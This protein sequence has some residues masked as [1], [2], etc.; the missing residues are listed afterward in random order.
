M[1]Y[2]DDPGTFA[3]DDQYL[4]GESLLVAPAFAGQQARSVYLPP[5][6]WFDFWTA[7][8]HSGKGRVEVDVP[9]DRIPLFVKA[10]ALLPLARPTLH[11][12]D[13]ASRQLTMHAYGNQPAQTV[14]YEDDGS[15][16]PALAQVA[17]FW[18]AGQQEGSVDR[19]GSGTG[20]R[21]EVAQ[22]KRFA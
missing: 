2:P 21:F 17:L 14:L 12:E 22:W 18:E 11:V 4:V 13:P 10:G 15:A 20:P 16:R 8:K 5:G 19:K 6:D 9:L 7:Q 3:V 1:D